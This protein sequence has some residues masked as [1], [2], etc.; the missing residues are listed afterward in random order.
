V[1]LS[2]IALDDIHET[3]EASALMRKF[4]TTRLYLD[5]HKRY[6]HDI[7]ASGTALASYIIITPMQ[8]EKDGALVSITATGADGL[9]QVPQGY[10]LDARVIVRDGAHY[11]EYDAKSAITDWIR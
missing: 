3:Q 6:T 5:D 4:D 9:T 10:I 8:F 11:R 2:G 7:T 1:T